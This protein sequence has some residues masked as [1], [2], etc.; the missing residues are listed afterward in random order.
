MSDIR[1]DFEHDLDLFRSELSLV[2][3]E[4]AIQQQLRIRL[5]F[6]LGEWFLD[7]QVGVPFYRDILIKNP[8]LALIRDVFRRA[9]ITTPGIASVEEL[10]VEITDKALRVLSVSFRATMDTG[11]T[12]DFE[13]FNIQV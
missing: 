4:E 11:E 3:G 6:F 12:L 13:P 8:N 10:N 2:Q 7:T 9:I 1:L 5:Q